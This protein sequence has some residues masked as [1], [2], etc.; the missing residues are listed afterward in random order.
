MK[1]HFNFEFREF[2]ITDDPISHEVA[3]KIMRY[4]L[5]PMQA[6]R[7]HMKIP[8]IVSRR[9]GYRPVWYEEM[10]GRSGNSQHTFS[11]KGAADYTM[12]GNWKEFLLY[13]AWLTDYTRVCY[14]PNN[15][16][17]HCDYAALTPTFFTAQSPAGSWKWHGEL[18]T[19]IESLD[20][21]SL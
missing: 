1:R 13:I 6:V 3:N 8:I 7:N 4:H 21:S 17:V 20:E 11:G 18:I 12:S 10:K 9:S 14:Y 5:L 19:A 16:F 15:N 2:C